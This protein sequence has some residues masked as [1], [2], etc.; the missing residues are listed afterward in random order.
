MFRFFVW[1]E[2]KLPLLEFSSGSFYA[3]SA[4]NGEFSPV[5]QNT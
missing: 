3:F 5:Q 2:K 4:S 1:R